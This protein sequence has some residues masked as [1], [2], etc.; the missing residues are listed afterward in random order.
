[1]RFCVLIH[2]K[3]IPWGSNNLH[4]SP[5]TGDIILLFACH[6]PHFIICMP[7]ATEFQW[8]DCVVIYFEIVSELRRKHLFYSPVP[9]IVLAEYTGLGCCV[10]LD[11]RRPLL[12]A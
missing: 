6:W 11:C 10:G 12:F 5:S 9:G 7:L 8:V 4:I 1:M 2:I 3:L